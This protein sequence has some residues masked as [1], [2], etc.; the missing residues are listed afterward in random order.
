[1]KKIMLAC[2]FISSPIIAG[3]PP[4]L[5]PCDHPSRYVIVDKYCVT[6]MY[7]MIFCLVLDRVDGKYYAFAIDYFDQCA[8][9]EEAEILMFRHRPMDQE[10]SKKAFPKY[11]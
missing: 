7:E 3:T 11:F 8:F 5:K 2:M 9:N 10:D 1:M 6:S 4:H